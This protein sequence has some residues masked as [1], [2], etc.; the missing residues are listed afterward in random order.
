MNRRRQEIGFTLVEMLVALFI[1]SLISLGTMSA[2][3]SAL[4]GKAQLKEAGDRVAEIETA[5]AL[6]KSDLSNLI[7]RPTRDGYGNTDLY[8]I[9]GGVDAL[10]TFTRAGRD[11]PG[12]LEKRGDLQRVSYVFENGDFIRRT[13]TAM[14]PPPQAEPVDRVLISGLTRAEVT[15][16]TQELEYTQ[17]FLPVNEPRLPYDRVE[18]NLVTDKGDRLTQIFEL[19]P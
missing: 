13:L 7:L 17:L 8:L 5:R 9:S 16:F 4:R 6:I 14:N 2:M 19:A 15:F 11:N 3:T 10:L 1:F 12:G 18:F